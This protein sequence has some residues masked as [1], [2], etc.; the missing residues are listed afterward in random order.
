MIH[1]RELLLVGA[2]ALAAK[3]TAS[4]LACAGDGP[5]AGDD[6]KAGGGKKDD[7]KKDDGKG[8]GDHAGHGDHG[9][10]GGAAPAG[11]GEAAELVRIAAAC[12]AAGNTCMAHCLKMLS[13]GDKSMV[14]CAKTVSD[15]IPVCEMIGTLAAA[16]SEH[17]G[18]AAKLCHEVCTSCSKACKAHQG[19]HE[20]CKACFEACEASIKEAAKHMA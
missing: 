12:V 2:G 3:A 13:T 4:T 11:G 20:E 19:H 18:T 9:G 17:L 8:G 16:G 15:M 6:G 7:G 14:E 10:D 1:R 5:P